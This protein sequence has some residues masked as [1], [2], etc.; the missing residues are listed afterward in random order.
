[1]DVPLEIQFE[2]RKKKLDEDAKYR[3]REY[4]EKYAVKTFLDC[5]EPTKIF[6]HHVID[7][8]KPLDEVVSQVRERIY[9]N[10]PLEVLL[11]TNHIK[12]FIINS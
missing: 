3:K 10:A 11:K 2:R 7:A 5:V 6:A 9:N 1:M 8:I 4:F 12:A